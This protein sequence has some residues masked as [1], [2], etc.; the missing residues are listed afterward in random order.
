MSKEIKIRKDWGKVSPETKV[1]KVKT[2]YDRKSNRQAIEDALREAEE[3]A[4]FE[5]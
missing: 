5:I 4:D 3:D 1:E 2:E